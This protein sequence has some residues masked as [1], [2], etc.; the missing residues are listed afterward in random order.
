MF[1]WESY[2]CFLDV[3]RSFGSD[4]RSDRVGKYSRDTLLSEERWRQSGERELASRKH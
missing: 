4:E 2:F 3:L 1:L